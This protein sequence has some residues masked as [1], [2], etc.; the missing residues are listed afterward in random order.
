MVATLPAQDARHPVPE[1]MI[2]KGLRGRS[3]AGS[4]FHERAAAI[5]GTETTWPYAKLNAL[6]MIAPWLVTLRI[7]Q[8]VIQL[9]DFK[10]PTLNRSNCVFLIGSRH[11]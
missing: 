11:K 2:F 4:R 7:C 9:N 1:H 5:W 3:R 8:L 10:P 6:N